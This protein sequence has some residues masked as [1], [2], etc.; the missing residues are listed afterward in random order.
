M[1]D[2]NHASWIGRTHEA[3]DVAAE[4]P[5]RRLA[6]LLDH[7]G[8]HWPDEALPPLGHWL[9]H[10]PDT[11]QSGLGRDGHPARGG[12]L[13]PIARPRRM[14]AGS[15]VTFHA[16]IRF[17][18]AM[19][20]RTILTR[21]EDKGALTFVTLSHTIL[22][23]GAVAVEEEQDLVYLAINSPRPPKAVETATAE[24]VRHHR[25][26]ETLLFRFSA[27]T[28]NAH[29]IHYD[30]GYAR[31]VELYPALVVHAPLQAMLLVDHVLRDGIELRRFAF[32]A[33][34]PLYAP[35]QFTT[36]RAGERMWVRDAAGTVTMT[37]ER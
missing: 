14:W 13:P 20:K 18:A 15:R 36:S 24:T 30:L 16:P 9:F 22:A 35:G 3:A 21:I 19:T 32:R 2:H 5:V 31:A 6:A 17:G 29:R 1:A 23:D 7:D 25:A 8:A 26:E 11:A 37:A 27:V 28:F 12:F 10:L 34:A 4:A 33:L